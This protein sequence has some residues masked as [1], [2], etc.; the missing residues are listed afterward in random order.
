MQ[1]FNLGPLGPTKRLKSREAREDLLSMRSTD[2]PERLLT[3]GSAPD[4]DSAALERDTR[5]LVPYQS[6]IL[7]TLVESMLLMDP[8]RSSVLELGC[9]NG[10]LTARLLE[11]K[12]YVRLTAVEPDVQMILATRDRL[13]HRAEGVEL[14]C[15]ELSCFLRPGAFDY[16][17]SNLALH[18]LA[19]A[20]DKSMVCRN[21]FESLKPGGIFAFSVML[22]SGSEQENRTNWAKWERDVKAAG[23][24]L[25]AIREWGRK[26]RNV[27]SPDSPELW[28]GRLKT[29]GFV[30]S[31]IVW[32][33]A[34]FGTIW[35]KKS[36]DKT[37][38]RL[39]VPR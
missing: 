3:E 22:T 26:Y 13:G 31:D 30:L 7:D 33:E 24:G 5:L 35:A 18:L 21:V 12:P 23:A 9:R 34:V 28:I 19:A 16:V 36:A 4:P 25:K 11:E 39:G 17:L 29:A 15:E 20:D 37:P 1:A 8:E 32:A 14:I 2:E 10:L 38:P 27:L 6:D